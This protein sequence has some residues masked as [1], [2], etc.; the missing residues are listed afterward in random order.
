MA[1]LK[2]F[3]FEDLDSAM[4]KVDP[5]GSMAHKNQYSKITEWIPLGNYLLNAQV[6]GSL[7]KGMPN[8]RSVAFSGPSG[9]LHPDTEIEVYISDKRVTRMIHEEEAV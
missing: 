8:S 3:S 9:C 6:S 7:K 1:A 5:L 4:T 2:Q